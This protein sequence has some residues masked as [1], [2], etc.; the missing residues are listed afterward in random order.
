MLFV[1]LTLHGYMH[2]Q[3]KCLLHSIACVHIQKRVQAQTH[4]EHDIKLNTENDT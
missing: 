3:V 2:I 4:T 1:R